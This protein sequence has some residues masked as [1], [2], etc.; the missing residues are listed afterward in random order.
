[1]IDWD[2]KCLI[3]TCESIISGKTVIRSISAEVFYLTDDSDDDEP[4]GVS[5]IHTI[6]C[7]P[8]DRSYCGYRREMVRSAI[9]ETRN[10]LQDQDKKL[11]KEAA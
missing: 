2:E 4:I 11:N 1:M 8:K 5:S 3:D 10:Y 9:S 7:D 6:V